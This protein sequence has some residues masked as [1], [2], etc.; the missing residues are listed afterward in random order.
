MADRGPLLLPRST[1]S[2]DAPEYNPRQMT[3]DE[4]TGLLA[5]IQ[6]GNGDAQARLASLVYDYL[7]S[8]AARYMYHERP[9]QSLQ[10]TVLVHDAFLQLVNQEDR[11]WQNRAHFFAVAAQ[12]MRRILI[13]H[14][15]S[16]NTAKRGG[17][18]PR[19]PLDE[20]VIASDENWDDLLDV[21]QALTRLAERD[22]RLSR[23]VEL[24]FFSGMTEKEIGAVIG[25]S[26]RQV[27]RE[28]KVAKAWLRAELS[29]RK[30]KND[31]SGALGAS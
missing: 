11:N 9:E 24:R 8:M 23:I 3:P 4:I 5:E 29:G 20:A 1:T 13:D 10:T 31:D 16:R 28:W 30:D 7:H 19:K 21:D 25:L 27:K 22:A 14:A 6:G 12:L 18:V 17:N 2:T 26:E 15:R